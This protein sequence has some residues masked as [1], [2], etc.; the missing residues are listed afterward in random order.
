MKEAVLDI[1]IQA[2]VD[3]NDDLNIPAL[4]SPEA[5][6]LLYG[7]DGNLD[8]IGLVRLISDVEDMI[9]T[10]LN[11]RVVLADERAMSRTRSPFRSIG[12]LAEYIEERLA[13]DE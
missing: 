11:R 7:K 8:S 13:H 12:V 5:T 2:V 9:F 1:V 4:N 3:L 6:T 10:R